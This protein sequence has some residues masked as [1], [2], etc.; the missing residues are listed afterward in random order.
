MRKVFFVLAVLLLSCSIPRKD[1]NAIRFWQFWSDINTKPV[2]EQLIAEFELANPG[3]KVEITDLT[4]ANGQDKLVI[5]FAAK[6]P[7]D[8]MELGSDWIAQ[9]SS[10]GLL[11]EFE[12]DLP[13]N[14]LYP[15]VWNEKLY[16]LPWMLDSRIFYFNIDLLQKAKIKTPN[17]WPELLKACRKIDLLGDECFGFGSNSAEKHR[18]YKKF[19]PFLWCNGGQILSEDNKISALDTKESVGALD[20]YLDLCHCGIIESQS[21]IEEYF[22]EGKVGFVISGGWLLRRL[23]KTPPDFKYRLVPIFRSGGGTGTS[24]FGGEYIA[25]Y[26]KSKKMEMAKKLAEFLTSKE[27]SQRLC[28]AAGFGFP[29]YNDLTISDPEQRI[30]AQQ[31]RNSRATPPT[32]IWIDIEQDIED[33]IEAAM[34]GHGTAREVLTKASVD[35]N[36]K[37]RNLENETA[38]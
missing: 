20:F 6:A 30:M 28:D 7:P 21:R 26:A 35:I 10:N 14:Y 5:S 11:T 3:T 27:N 23:K 37:L 16:A 8:V 38:K 17:D 4:W 13:E 36:T 34:Y 9:F 29:P 25:V 32:P 15:A 22:R 31:L 18:L 33:A 12:S 19:L 24:F 2:I 1:E